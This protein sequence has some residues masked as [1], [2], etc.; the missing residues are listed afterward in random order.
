MGYDKGCTQYQ[1]NC[2]WCAEEKGGVDNKYNLEVSFS[3]GKYHC[4]SCGSSGPISKLIRSRGGKA[5]YDEYMSVIKDIKES[6]YYNIEMF[7]DNGELFGETYLRL[8]KTFEKI[9]LINCRDKEL[10]AY[11]EKRKIT[12][13]IIDEYGIGRTTWGEEDW[14][15]RNRIVFPSYDSN[16]FLNYFIG[17]SYRSKDKRTKYKNCD[18]DKNKIILHE[19]KICWD[20]DIY[21]VEGAID[22]IYYKNSISLMGKTLNKKMELYSKLKEKANANIIICLDGD[23]EIS[24]VKRI[25]KVL[26]NGRLRGKIR[27]IRLGEGVNGRYVRY[28]PPEIDGEEV[29]INIEFV[30]VDSL[31]VSDGKNPQ[32]VVY[33]DI[34]YTYDGYKDF[35]E[36]YESEG[37]YGIMRA[38]KE[39]RQFDEVELLV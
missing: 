22:C 19:D 3:I 7:A 21:L 1:F 34:L 12:Q 14:T 33:K 23:T 26:D 5:L 29:K 9:N 18:A 8:P 6:G 35:G 17:R 20:A 27:Y 16:G 36:I 24:E 32:Y 11:L 10:R 38:M 25:Y 15:W 31:A 28:T 4:W 30:P 37:R 2:P 39:A 13:D